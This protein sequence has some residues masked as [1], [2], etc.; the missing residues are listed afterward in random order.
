MQE[1]KVVRSFR[2]KIK[3][4]STKTIAKPP[5]CGLFIKLMSKDKLFTDSQ[6]GS[7][8]THCNSVTDFVYFGRVQRDREREG[9]TEKE[10]REK[11]TVTDRKP[12]WRVGKCG[13]CVLLCDGYANEAS[14][15]VQFCSCLPESL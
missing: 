11:W 1:C 10:N 8:I 5:F 3:V 7:L 14:H 6:R 4:K 9:K 13:E 12:T 15:C 2:I